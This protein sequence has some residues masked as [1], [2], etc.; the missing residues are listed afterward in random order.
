ME[1]LNRYA[2]PHVQLEIRQGGGVL[3]GW[4][5]QGVMVCQGSSVFQH[6]IRALTNSWRLPCPRDVWLGIAK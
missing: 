2:D 4:L 6:R 1:L 3:K 5:P